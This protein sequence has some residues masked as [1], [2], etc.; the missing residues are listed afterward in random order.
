M[1]ISKKNKCDKCGCSF[2]NKDIVTA[3]ITNVEVDDRRSDGNI[4]LKLSEKSIKTRSI[5][6]FCERCL[7]LSLYQE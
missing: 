5:R 2:Q 4:H 6:I 1:A 7:D 3:I